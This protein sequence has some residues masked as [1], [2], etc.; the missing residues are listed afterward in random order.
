MPLS[1]LVSRAMR[2]IRNRQAASC[3]QARELSSVRS[4]SLPAA[5]HGK[6]LFHH[7]AAGDDREA[8][9]F[10]RLVHDLYQLRKPHLLKRRSQLRALITAIGPQPDDRRCLLQHGT[11]HHRGPVTILYRCLMHDDGNREPFY[12]YGNVALAPLDLLAPVIAARPAALRRL[13]RLA[14]N[15]RCRR[16]LLAPRLDPC[17]CTQRASIREGAVVPP[18]IEMVLHRGKRRIT[19]GSDAT[20]TP[21]T[22]CTGSRRI[23]G[24]GLSPVAAPSAPAAGSGVRSRPI[25]DHFADH[26]GDLYCAR[27]V[28]VHATVPSIVGFNSR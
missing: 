8:F 7:P 5:G 22:A 26:Y 19:L 27:V 25:R 1:H 3:T 24:A 10:L 20:G 21:T 16:I 12:I 13:H 4:K 11:D 14:V 23:P 2:R 28:S 18:G 17:L 9:A 6:G 15:D